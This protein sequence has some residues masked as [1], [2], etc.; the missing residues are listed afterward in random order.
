MKHCVLQNGRLAP[1]LEARLEKLFDVHPLWKESDVRSFLARRGGDFEGLVTSAPAGAST[2]LIESMPSLKVISCHGVGLDKIDLEAARRRGIGVAGTPGVLT[3]CVADF[4]F[5]LLIDVARQLSA[6]DRFV[7]AGRWGEEKYPL[8]TRVSGKRLGIV[9][10]GRIGQALAKR[11][12]GFDMEIRYVDRASVDGVT[13]VREDSLAALARWADFLVVTVAAG[14]DTS[15]MIDGAVLDALGPDGFLVNVSRGTVIDETALVAALTSRAIAGAAL[16][17][18]A[19]EPN[20]PAA[21][22]GLDNVVLLPHTA[23]GTIETRTAMQDLVV[24]NLTSF[25]ETGR[26][27]TPAI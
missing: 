22:L 6:A 5:G 1:A 17:V 27:V 15:R 19:D 7:R 3:D 20:V 25:F 11:A 2:E 13:F 18:Y 8:T 10:L 21:L 24:A 26:L 4:A 23:S 9:G 12:G 16:D 14:P